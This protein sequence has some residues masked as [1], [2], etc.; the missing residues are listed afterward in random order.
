MLTNTTNGTIE[1]DGYLGAVQRG[2]VDMFVA[3]FTPTNERLEYFVFSTPY[4]ID[5]WVVAAPINRVQNDFAD[6]AFLLFRMFTAQVEMS[7]FL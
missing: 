7:V 1:F 6:H 2:D 4:M 3:D 5:D